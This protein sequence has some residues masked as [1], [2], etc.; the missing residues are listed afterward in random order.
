MTDFYPSGG[1]YPDKKWVIDGGGL[2]EVDP[3]LITESCI[4]TPHKKEFY[5]LLER[6]VKRPGLAKQGQALSETCINLSQALNNC[7]IILKG[8]KD[9]VC[10]GDHCVE[11]SGGPPSLATRLWELFV[12][13]SWRATRRAGNPGMTKGG[14]GDVLAGLTAAFYTKN[15]QWA[16]AAMASY[17]NKKAGDNLYKRVGPYF[18]AEDLVRE[19]PL[20]IYGI[21]GVNV[22]T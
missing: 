2:Q 22:S 14:T 13:G 8:Q 11:I 6:T 9:I 17:I 10:Q 7:A 18:N 4:L 1:K 16:A 20:T 19:V 15:S 12:H 3:S 5:G 21:M